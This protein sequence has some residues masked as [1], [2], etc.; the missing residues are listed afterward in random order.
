MKLR[1]IGLR[2]LP[3]VG[4]GLSSPSPLVFIGGPSARLSAARATNHAGVR[5]HS[6]KRWT[7]AFLS[8]N[9]LAG[10][11]RSRISAVAASTDGFLSFSG[12]PR[13]NRQYQSDACRRYA[14]ELERDPRRFDQR[15]AA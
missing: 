12:Q 3:L 11:V 4:I 10:L 2:S 6:V 5:P 13:A 8:L 7:H 15:D 1:P 14:L 9:A